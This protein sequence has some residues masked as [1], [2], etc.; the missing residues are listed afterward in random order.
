MGNLGV[1]DGT[2]RLNKMG[3]YPENYPVWLADH[4]RAC[5]DYLYT[6][7][8]QNGSIGSVM[9][10]EWFPNDEDK[11]SVLVLLD[12]MESLLTECEKAILEQWKIKNL[13]YST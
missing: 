2:K 10:D 1:I 13:N 4:P 6:A 12:K 7:V 3:Y 11:Q 5:V 9:L 8:L